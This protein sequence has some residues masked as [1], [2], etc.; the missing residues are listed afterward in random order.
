MAVYAGDMD[1]KFHQEFP[2]PEDLYA[3]DRALHAE[4]KRRLPA[5]IAKRAAP[6]F[7]AMGKST[8]TDLPALMV[9]A[10]ANEPV[11]VPYDPWGRRVDEIRVSRAWGELKKHAAQ[12]AIVATGYDESYGEHRRVVQA[13]LLHLYSASSAIYSC[14][15]AMTDAAARVLKDI[16]P[17]AVRDRL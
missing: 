14:P 1:P 17:P 7:E 15:L 4:L 5:D 6:K 11:H 13:A 12:H 10:E 2:A 3:V 8:A 9:D 16:A